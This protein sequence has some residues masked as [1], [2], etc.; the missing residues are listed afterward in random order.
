MKRTN[1]AATFTLTGKVDEGLATIDGT[2]V[3]I[4]SVAAYAQYN[5][6]NPKAAYAQARAH[7]HATYWV[8][9]VGSAI[10]SSKAYYAEQTRRWAL[11]AVL[12]MGDTI[13]ITDAMGTRDFVI[14][15]T[16][17]GNYLLEPTTP[18]AKMPFVTVVTDTD[19]LTG[20]RGKRWLSRQGGWTSMR[21]YAG[22][23]LSQK[24]A[25]AEIRKMKERR[26]TA[27]EGVRFSFEKVVVG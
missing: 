1:I 16:H 25:K 3:S 23:F 12:K 27:W 22:L 7:G 19:P 26:P 9:L 13:R 14:R 10:T 6:E 8:N 11:R 15:P 21:P 17:N 24:D 5:L 4:G 20:V 2:K 18:W